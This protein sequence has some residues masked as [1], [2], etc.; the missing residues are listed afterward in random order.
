MTYA[1][2]REGALEARQYAA[3]RDSRI[4]ALCVARMAYI[5]WRDHDIVRLQKKLIDDSADREAAAKAQE[6]A[7]SNVTAIRASGLRPGPKPEVS[8]WNE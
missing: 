1:K 3:F 7:L 6:E 2:A 5:V 8:A 4:I